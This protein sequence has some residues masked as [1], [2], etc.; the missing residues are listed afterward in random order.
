MYTNPSVQ[1]VSLIVEV[2]TASSPACNAY[3]L[4]V[5]GSSGVSTSL[6]DLYCASNPNSTGV[7][8]IVSGIGSIRAA[9]NRL[10]LE[11]THVPRQTSVIFLTSRTPGRIPNPIGHDGILCF[12]GGI[13]RFIGPGEIQFT[14]PT[15]SA[16]LDVD[17][18]S[19]PEGVGFTSVVPGDVWRF[20]GWFRD[21]RDGQA[22]SN[23][24][25]ALAIRF[26]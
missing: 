8:A 5:D 9:D 18:T 12:G 1:T 2:R 20:Q 15:N 7:R 23:F 19:V 26:Q 21:V 13:G 4:S 3:R 16:R 6:G 10:T 25:D 24:T 14:G 11:A 22:T 17:L